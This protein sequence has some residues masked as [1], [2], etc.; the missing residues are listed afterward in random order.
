M[1]TSE[2]TY[3]KDREKPGSIR[4]GN[5]AEEHINGGRAQDENPRLCETEMTTSQGCH[6]PMHFWAKVEH[7]VDLVTLCGWRKGE[8]TGLHWDRTW[9]PRT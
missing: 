3:V 8:K 7:C 1:K 9:D 4:S 6:S 5:G 2:S